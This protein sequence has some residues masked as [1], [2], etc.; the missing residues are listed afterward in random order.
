MAVLVLQ[1]AAARARIIATDLLL[2]V[3][4]GIA[5]FLT[6]IGSQ[7]IVARLHSGE[8]RV[9]L[10]S[11]AHLAVVVLTQRNVGHEKER[12]DALVDAV[13]HLL[14][15]IVALELVD[16]QRILLFVRGRLNGLL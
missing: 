14:K 4:R 5:L 10:L 3:D 12:D 13:H 15:E 16:K 2:D 9:L 11:L 1:A 7:V 6:A 8:V